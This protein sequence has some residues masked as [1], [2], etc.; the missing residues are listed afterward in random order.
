[1]GNVFV[2]RIV[3]VV[4]NCSRSRNAGTHTLD[5][6]TLQT[7]YAKLLT[8]PFASHLLIEYPSVEAVGVVVAPNRTRKSNMASPCVALIEKYC[9]ISGVS[10][11]FFSCCFAIFVVW[12]F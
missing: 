4:E 6:E 8:E 3:E 9:C 12:V 2:L 10:L 7:P 1:M 5:A 11:L